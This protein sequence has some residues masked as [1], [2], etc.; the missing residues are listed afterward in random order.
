MGEIAEMML[1]GTM[2]PETGEFNFDGFDGP[3]WPM[4]GAE[5]AAYKRQ[6][7]GSGL[8]W[9]RSPKA[10]GPYSGIT[11]YTLTKA[12]RK[13]LEKFGEVAPNDPYH[14]QIRRAGKVV[15]DWWPHKRKYRL[16]GQ[17]IEVGFEGDLRDALAASDGAPSASTTEQSSSPGMNQ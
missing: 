15:A 3:G 11:R 5:A 1:D 13:K 10:P 17:P 7:G 14:W 4:T 16:A 9:E 12:W 8:H 2:D 6:T